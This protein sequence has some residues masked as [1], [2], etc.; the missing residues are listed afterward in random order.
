MTNDELRSPFQN[1]QFGVPRIVRS[2]FNQVQHW[3]YDPCHKARN[4]S[5]VRSSSKPTTDW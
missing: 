3:P 5:R 4:S 1:S 2:V